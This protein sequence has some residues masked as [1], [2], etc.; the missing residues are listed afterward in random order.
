MTVTSIKIFKVKK[1]DSKVKAV[2]SITIDDSLVI[3]GIKV[4]TGTKGLFISMPSTKDADG[5]YHDTVY[6][7]KAET[8]EK[9]QDMIVK[10]YNE[11]A[12]D[13]TL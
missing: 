11:V 7:I 8:R 3:T 4:V 12:N 13:N 5:E 10:K 9:L 1:V 6:P 2:A